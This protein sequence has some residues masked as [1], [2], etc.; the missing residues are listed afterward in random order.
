MGLTPG[1]FTWFYDN[2]QIYDRHI[3]NVNIM[4]DREGINC[5][6]EIWLNPDKRDFYDFTMDDIKIVG[7]P[8]EL[9]KKKNPQLK[10]P[11]AK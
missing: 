7:Y 1:R 9:V 8:R 2:I 11:V 10:F 3:D 5:N 4:L 6:P